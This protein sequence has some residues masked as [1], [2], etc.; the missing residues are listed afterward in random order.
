MYHVRHAHRIRHTQTLT[1]LSV[2]PAE[3][4]EMENAHDSGEKAST[5]LWEIKSSLWLV[6]PTSKPILSLHLEE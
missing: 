2:Q 4:W 3:A 6:T 1:H 5:D